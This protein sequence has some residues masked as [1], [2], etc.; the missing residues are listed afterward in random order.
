MKEDTISALTAL[1]TEA[2]KST[3]KIVNELARVGFK[4]R[5]EDAVGG[6]LLPPTMGD[7]F[8]EQMQAANFA[9][10]ALSRYEQA[11]NHIHSAP[12]FRPL[13]NAYG[14]SSRFG[15]RR[16]PFTGRTA[17]HSGLDF[18]APRGTSVSALG[19]GRVTFAG[20]K[21]GY[22]NA[23]EITHVNGLVSRYAHLSKIKV[24]KGQQV[25]PSHN[26]WFGWQHRAQHRTTFAS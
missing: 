1:G 4:P 3:T 14:L 22:G 15:N 26:Y 11:K 19:K 16:D 24:K 5:F 23:V 6:P 25:T 20:R 12:I 2:E 10:D 9:L 18:R 21:G 13:P 8:A 17:F 7:A